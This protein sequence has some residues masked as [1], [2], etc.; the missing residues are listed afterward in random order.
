MQVPEQRDLEAWI[1]Q[2]KLF[3]PWW[4][5]PKTNLKRRKWHFLVCASVKKKKKKACLELLLLFCFSSSPLGRGHPCPLHRPGCLD[6]PNL[7]DLTGIFSESDRPEPSCGP[8]LPGPPRSLACTLGLGRSSE[9]DL[10]PHSWPV[11]LTLRPAC[12]PNQVPVLHVNP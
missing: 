3:I 12:A 1:L 2:S 11:C 8:H 5:L 10:S 4:G 9:W 6:V 7:G